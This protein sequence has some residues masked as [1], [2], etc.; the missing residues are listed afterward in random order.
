M[1]KVNLNEFIKDLLLYVKYDIEE[2]LERSGEC[3]EGPVNFFSDFEYI[4]EIKFGKNTFLNQSSVIV[5][6]TTRERTTN[7]FEF[8]EL[9]KY[10]R[11]NSFS[12]TIR[13]LDKPEQERLLDSFLDDL[14]QEFESRGWDSCLVGF[15]HR[16]IKRSNS[17]QSHFVN[18]MKK[19][20][21]GG[22]SKNYLMRYFSKQ[23]TEEI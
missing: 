4:G 3:Y 22:V 18:T 16:D 6:H 1:S 11:N 21:G 5:I 23:Y 15:I 9:T 13:V 2:D 10:L 19:L 7:L 14:I 8:P 20:D 17:S 12:P